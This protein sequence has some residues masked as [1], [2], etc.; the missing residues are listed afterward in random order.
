MRVGI[1]LLLSLLSGGVGAWAHKRFSPPP[2]GTSADALS[3]AWERIHEIESRM[4]AVEESQ[5]R[6][7]SQH[8]ELQ[9][10][11]DR[12]GGQIGSA[13]A[14]LKAL[15][16]EADRTSAAI[17]AGR[18]ETAR[19]GRITSYAWV[20]DSKQRVGEDSATAARIQQRVTAKAMLP[21]GAG[22]T[23]LHEM[24]RQACEALLDEMRA[25]AARVTFYSDGDD[26]DS[27]SP[28]A[29]ATLAPGGY[30]DQTLRYPDDALPSRHH[31]R[32]RV[33]WQD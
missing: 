19:V 31:M 15:A 11:L 14:A 2:P 6:V 32:L 3:R 18:A 1:V 5:Q 23:E 9:S 30:W 13:T 16:E 33:E 10:S 20:D 22:R 21:T 27:G 4:R 7:V 24:M 25:S 28:V 12:L 17:K 8:A 26:P 29:Y